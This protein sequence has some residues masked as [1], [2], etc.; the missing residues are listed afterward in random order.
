M[1]PGT[2]LSL[3]E[4]VGWEKRVVHG[5]REEGGGGGSSQILSLGCVV[6]VQES[7]FFGLPQSISVSL[8]LLSVP[9]ERDPKTLFGDSGEMK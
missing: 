2:L 4:G 3:S 5:R 9:L 6:G 1:L 7:W 8:S